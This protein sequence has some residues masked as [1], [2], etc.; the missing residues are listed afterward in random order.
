MGSGCKRG[1]PHD[2]VPGGSGLTGQVARRPRDPVLSPTTMRGPQGLLQAPRLRRP[3]RDPRPR[4]G[5][6]SHLRRLRRHGLE[7]EQFF[8]RRRRGLPAAHGPRLQGYPFQDRRVGF[9][10]A[11]WAGG[12]GVWGMAASAAVSVGVGSAVCCGVWRRTSDIRSCVC[13]VGMASGS[14]QVVSVIRLICVLREREHTLFRT[15]STWRKHSTAFARAIG[16][17][18]IGAGKVDHASTP[19][20]P[21][22]RWRLS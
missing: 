3:H 17:R 22:L 10:G 9:P 11:S 12:R 5:I 14:A 13:V 21:R 2:I 6:R 16:C 19:S 20:T 1:K 7:G 4:E 15:V 18:L 8:L